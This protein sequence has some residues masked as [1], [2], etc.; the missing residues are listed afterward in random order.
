MSLQQ[1]TE[2]GTVRR[3]AW[4]CVVSLLTVGAIAGTLSARAEEVAA[5]PLYAVAMT[6][7]VNGE[8]SAPRVLAKA[9]EKFA[10]ASGEWRVE[11]TVRQAQTFGDVWL[12]GKLFKGSEVVSAPT[13]LAHLNKKATIKVG[14]SSTPFALSMIVSPQP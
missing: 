14:D 10:V 11:M 13:L 8:Q 1:L 7:D 5:A 6:H 12:A 3:L 2:S 4:R 9:G